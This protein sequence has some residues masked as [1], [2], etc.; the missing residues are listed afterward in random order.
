MV[1]QPSPRGRLAALVTRVQALKP[2]RVFLHYSSRRGPLLSAGLSYQAIFAVFAAI[3]LAF[4]VAG[5]VLNANPALRG[6]LF[7]L[8]GTAVPGLIDRGN[9]GAIDPNLLLS[10][11]VLGWTGALALV[12]TL[13]TAIGWLGSARDAVR[14]IAG[15]ASPATHFAL[16]KLRDLGLALAFGV[17]LLVSAALSVGSTA[18]LAWLQSLV[19]ID[20]A[21][22]AATITTRVVGLALMF[23]LDVGTLV[24]LYRVLAGVPIPRRPLIQGAVLGAVALGVLKV[25]GSTLLGGA[26]SNPLLASFAVI[27]GLLIWFN[28]VCQVILLGAAWVVVSATDAGSPLDPIG[29]AKRRADEARL[30]DRLEQEIRAEIEAEVPRAVRWL[31]H[32]TQ[33]KRMTDE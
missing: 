5:L 7:D 6:A 33:R 11:G 16:L 2:V 24:A 8:I 17:A 32:R 18:A 15:L 19:G 14:D 27:I 29:D 23:A 4:S 10:T 20:S 26:S 22:L 12:G 21:S 13:F 31:I 3:W 28:L 1:E 30:R 25:L 9:G